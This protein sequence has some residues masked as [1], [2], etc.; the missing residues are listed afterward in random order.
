MVEI[1]AWLTSFNSSEL[2]SKIMKNGELSFQKSLG[3]GFQKSFR[4]LMMHKVSE[5]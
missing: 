2:L 1:Y 4:I 5:M 3:T